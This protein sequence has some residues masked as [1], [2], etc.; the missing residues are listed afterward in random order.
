[1]DCLIPGKYIKLFA[2]TIQ[3]LAKIGDELYIEA[4]DSKVNL[5]LHSC[6]DT[7]S[8]HFVHSII[9]DRHSWRFILNNAFSIPIL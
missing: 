1:M 9:P 7:L 2:K 5:T 4:S 6:S 3:C 8:S